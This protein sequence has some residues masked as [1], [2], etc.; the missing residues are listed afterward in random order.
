METVVIRRNGASRYITIPA[1][2]IREH[3]LK[4]GDVLGF[5]SGTDGATLTII[6]CVP[7]QELEPESEPE[8]A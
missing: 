4:Q 8:A 7:E 1:A 5:K 2:F 3:D 6:A